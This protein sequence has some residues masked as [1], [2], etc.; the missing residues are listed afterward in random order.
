MGNKRWREL[1]EGLSDCRAL[2]VN[3]IGE[4]PKVILSEH[5]LEIFEV[6]GLIEEALEALFSGKSLAHMKRRD[7][8][9]CRGAGNAIGCC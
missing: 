3:V 4:T 5:G 7:M 8:G 9:P 2:L 6:E 1:A